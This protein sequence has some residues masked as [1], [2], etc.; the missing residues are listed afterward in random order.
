MVKLVG[1]I[2]IEIGSNIMNYIYFSFC[3]LCSHYEYNNNNIY[4]QKQNINKEKNKTFYER[5]K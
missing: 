3:S 1:I 5:L 2:I 4:L